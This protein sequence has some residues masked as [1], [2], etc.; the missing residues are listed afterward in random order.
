MFKRK[1]RLVSPEAE[2]VQDGE[3]DLTDCFICQK[4]GDG[5]LVSLFRSCKSTEKSS[6]HSTAESLKR[7]QEIGELPLIVRTQ[8]ENYKTATEL[9]A[10]F[11]KNQVVFHKTCMTRY[12]KHKFER[13]V[14]Q[15]NPNDALIETSRTSRKT[16]SARNFSEKCFFC[17]K[18]ETCDTRVRH[19][20]WTIVYVKQGTN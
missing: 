15:K 6:Y 3:M 2:S 14:K 19:S 1:F 4:D 10:E 16:I 11:T 7:F 8:A 18:L 9:A 17:D 20:T 12:D 13:K 5:K